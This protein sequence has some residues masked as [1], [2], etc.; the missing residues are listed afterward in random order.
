MLIVRGHGKGDPEPD[1]ELETIIVPVDGSRLG[2]QVL[3]HV[4]ALANALDLKV[5][6]LRATVTVEEFAGIMIREFKSDLQP[7]LPGTFRLGDTRNTVSDISKL[8][9]LDMSETV[10][11]VSPN[12]KVPGNCG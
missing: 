8:R 4:A 3:P 9:S 10:F 5:P 7:Q 2:E 11:L 12:R 6:L 1:I